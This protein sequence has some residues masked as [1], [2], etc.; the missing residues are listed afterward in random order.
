V[1]EDTAVAWV[2]RSREVTVRRLMDEVEWALVV[3]HGLRPV[4][5][6]AAGALLDISERQ[7]CAHPDWE[8]ADGE[9]RFSAPAPVVALLRTS[10]LAFAAPADSLCGGLERLLLHVKAE[11]EGQPRHRDPIF[12]RDNWRCAVPV[13]TSRR[14]LHDHHLLFR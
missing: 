12:A 11:W 14:N 9:I 13:C 4:A 2:A 7:M 10:I 8:L 1:S 6:P 5:P 3:G